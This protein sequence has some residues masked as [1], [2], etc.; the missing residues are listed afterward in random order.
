MHTLRTTIRSPTTPILLLT[1][2]LLTTGNWY[3]PSY[4]FPLLRFEEPE[5]GSGC[6]PR[7]DELLP[8]LVEGL[9][10]LLHG[11]LGLLHAVQDALAALEAQPRP[12]GAVGLAIAA[13]RLQLGLPLHPPSGLQSLVKETRPRWKEWKINLRTRLTLTTTNPYIHTYIHSGGTSVRALPV[14]NLM[15]NS[16]IQGKSLSLVEYKTRVHPLLR[17]I[18]WHQNFLS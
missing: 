15:I 12:R 18:Q 9:L 14:R 4:W 8:A 3:L 16:G 5:S 6:L 10:G 2:L 17:K 11:P 13:G 7:G 1:S